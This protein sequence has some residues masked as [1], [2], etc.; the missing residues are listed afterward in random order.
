MKMSMEHWWNDSDRQK[1]K[2]SEKIPSQCH[3]VNHI[4]HMD[5]PWIELGVPRRGAGD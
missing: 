1:L 4:Y 3:V 2:F 5:C